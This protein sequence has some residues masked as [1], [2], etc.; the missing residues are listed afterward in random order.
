MNELQCRYLAVV[1]NDC[2]LVVSVGTIVVNTPDIVA[3]KHRFHFTIKIVSVEIIK[4][5]I[6][7]EHSANG[8]LLFS[9]MKMVYKFD[10]NFISLGH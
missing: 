9:I 4:M 2:F 3:P 7:D 6:L 10:I 1:S 8:L 5:I